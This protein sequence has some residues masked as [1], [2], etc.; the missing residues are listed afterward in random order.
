MAVQKILNYLLHKTRKFK[1]V[2]ISIEILEK[3]M[4]KPSESANRLSEMI[5]KAM[6]DGEISSLEYDRI[7]MVADEDGHI[8]SQERRL[9]SE[10]QDMISNGTIR[11]VG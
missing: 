8:D 9:L 5:K 11:R 6:D 3:K 2:S 10:L 4:Q 7:M 1:R